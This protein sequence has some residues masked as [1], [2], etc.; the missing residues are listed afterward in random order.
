MLPRQG[1][2]TEDNSS[3][4]TTQSP[5]KDAPGEVEVGGALET[6]ARPFGDYVNRILK[7]V[8]SPLL[9]AQAELHPTLKDVKS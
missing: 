8:R 2:P 9:Q 6:K 4:R 7:S 3:P 1:L 5:E